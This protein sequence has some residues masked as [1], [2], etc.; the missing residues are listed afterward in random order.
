MSRKEGENIHLSIDPDADPVAV[1]ERLHSGIYI[2]V[3]RI[4][5]S[6]VRLG[7]EAPPE[8]LVVRGELAK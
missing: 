6:Q 5:G 4:T 7:I 8:V 2:D 1:L 3:T